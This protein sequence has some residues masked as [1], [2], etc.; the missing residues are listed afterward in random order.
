LNNNGPGVRGG[1]GE[2]KKGNNS[3]DNDERSKTVTAE[4]N[5]TV[6]SVANNNQADDTA[7]GWTSPPSKKSLRKLKK[8]RE[9]GRT[10]K[11]AD[12]PSPGF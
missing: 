2:D 12:F 4:P 7:Q 8:K 9:N 5:G 3:I 11:K 10:R 1:E 6:E